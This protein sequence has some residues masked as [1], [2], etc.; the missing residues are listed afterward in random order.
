MDLFD[1][2][3]FPVR[4]VLDRLMADK[5]LRS[6]LVYKRFK[7]ASFDKTVGHRVVLYDNFN[8][9]YGIR[10]RHNKKSVLIASGDVEI[11]DEVYLVRGSEVPTGMSL[12]D[13]MEDADGN[14][15]S[16]TSIDNIFDLAVMISVAGSHSI[17]S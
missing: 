4:R 11:G 12:K 15:Y 14:L 10:L 8:D 7:S 6:A 16:I 9:L 17:P 3:D 1:Q 2:I 13:R 5:H